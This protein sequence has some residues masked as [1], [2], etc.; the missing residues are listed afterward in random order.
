VTDTDIQVVF[1]DLNM[2]IMD[3]YQ[4]LE[5]IRNSEDE[6]IRNLPVIVVTGAEN[7]ELAKEKALEAGATDFITKPFN[8]T[9]LRARALAHAHYQRTT[10]ALQQTAR[11]DA[12]TQLGNQRFFEEQLAKDVS[13]ASRHRE[14]LAVMLI[15]VN[16][17][18]SLFVKIGR[19]GADSLIREVARTLSR[20]VRK[21]DSVARISVAR[22]ALSLPTAKP[23]GAVDLARR[24]AQHIA[25][26]K[27]KLRGEALQITV[28]VGVWVMQQGT[29]PD[30]SE[31]M[32]GAQ[33]ALQQAVT[34]GPG[35]VYAVLPV[36][37]TESADLEAISIDAALAQIGRGELD[38]VRERLPLLLKKLEPLLA[39]SSQS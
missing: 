9:D 32:Q 21:E 25:G 23:N 33:D 11:V 31:V 39:L 13:F 15:E 27:A 38:A 16:D 8:T 10:R 5:Q 4:L 12:A 3:G 2:P 34:Q 6:G 18:N 24:I 22:F 29:R 37:G 1:T 7:D 35:Q 14:N 19:A 28:S 20:A 26:F 30:L 17:F 36:A